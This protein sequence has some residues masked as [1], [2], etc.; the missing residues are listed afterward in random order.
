VSSALKKGEELA[1]QTT[2]KYFYG[3]PVKESTGVLN[4]ISSNLNLVKTWNITLDE[5]GSFS[6]TFDISDVEL[7]NFTL[8]TEITDNRGERGYSIKRIKHVDNLIT[9]RLSCPDII[10]S[11]LKELVIEG[12]VTKITGQPERQLPLL[13]M[14]VDPSGKTFPLL[15]RIN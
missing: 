14:L 10:T 3:D 11:Y 6:G 1:V 12:S 15:K 9:A 4:L 5:K 2:A 7:D 8:R 13:M